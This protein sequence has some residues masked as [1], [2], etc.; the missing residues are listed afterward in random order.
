MY[1]SKTGS[2]KLPGGGIDEGETLEAA[3][4]REVRE[5]TGYEV[6]DICELGIIEE[7]RYYCGMHQISYCF[8]A[9]A[10]KYVGTD[11]TDEEKTRG[12]EFR[13]YKTIEQVIDAI[14]GSSHIDEDGSRI[15]LEMMKL[16]EVTILENY[17]LNNTSIK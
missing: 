9:R 16:R 15:G 13:W 6:T 5:E 7:N 1:F 11:L 12:M 17:L 14:K 2:Y 8:A 4:R 10:G 3:L